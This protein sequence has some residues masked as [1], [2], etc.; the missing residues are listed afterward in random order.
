[1]MAIVAVSIT[2]IGSGSPSVS[3]YVARAEAVLR[4][5]PGLRYRL[6]PMFTTIQ[7]D[8]REIFDAIV[9]MHEAVAAA[10]AVRISSVI[11][12]DDRRDKEVSMEEK[13][14][15]V[16]AKLRAQKNEE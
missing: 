15:S 16:E 4:D 10:G 6:D 9:A 3:E 8:L 5:R 11:K 2:P 13:V 14:A 7:G 1:M 12:V